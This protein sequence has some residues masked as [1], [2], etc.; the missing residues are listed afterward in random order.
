LNDALVAQLKLHEG[1]R[2]LPYEDTEGYLTIGYGHNLD[3]PLSDKA[4]EQ[5]LLDDIETAESELDRL[6]PWWKELDEPRQNVLVDMMF[7][8]GA[9]RFMTFQKLLKALL[10]RDYEKAADEML[11][12]KWYTQV[13]TRA[14][15]LADM[16]RG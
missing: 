10:E 15:V 6:L 4:I 12:S 9:P 2:N 5:I 14:E 7:N 3:V 1:K 11:D 13:G 8:L 16:M